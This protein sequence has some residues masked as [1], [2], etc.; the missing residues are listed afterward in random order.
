LIC[1][2]DNVSK[3][4]AIQGQAGRAKMTTPGGKLIT[5]ACPLKYVNKPFL[6]KQ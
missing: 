2:I 3:N 1:F 5:L 6:Y 4:D